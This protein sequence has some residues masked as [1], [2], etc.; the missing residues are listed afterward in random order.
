MSYRF[1]IDADGELR[2]HGPARDV[3]R[4]IDALEAL[5]APEPAHNPAPVASGQLPA[6]PALVAN[7]VS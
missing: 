4:H 7:R 6:L 5:V 3:L 1:R 2:L